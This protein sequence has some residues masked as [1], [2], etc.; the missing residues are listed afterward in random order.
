LTDITDRMQAK[1]ELRASLEPFRA[2][3]N[4]M[5]KYLLALN[6]VEPKIEK[7]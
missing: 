6:G 1:E 4:A 5:D 2:L 3:V 7:G